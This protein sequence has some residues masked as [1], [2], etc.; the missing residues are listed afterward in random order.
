[1]RANRLDELAA[2]GFDESYRTTTRTIKV[3][4]S[5][6]EALVINGVP[7]H[8]SACPNEVHECKGCSNMVPM[9]TVYCGDCY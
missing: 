9:R 2:Y 4:C 1:M 8:E 3:R 5:E 7:C 6:C